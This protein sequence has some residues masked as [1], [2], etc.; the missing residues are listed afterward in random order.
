MKYYLQLLTAVFVL[1]TGCKNESHNK[2]AYNIINDNFIAIVDTIAYDYNKLRPA[3]NQTLLSERLKVYPITVYENFININN[4]KDAIIEAL[5]ADTIHNR[6]TYLNL[7]NKTPDYEN[8]K[9]NLREIKNAGLYK[10]VATEDSSVMQKK[11]FVGHLKFSEI[12]SNGEIGLA[13]VTIQDNVKSGIKKLVL[14]KYHDRKWQIN[15]EVLLEV[16]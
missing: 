5:N 11:N 6:K 15:Q 14:F 8:E 7:V 13:V 4:Y 12:L 1:F 10:L 16:W 9:I 3:P 2:D